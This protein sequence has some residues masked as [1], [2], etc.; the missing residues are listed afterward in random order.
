MSTINDYTAMLSSV[1][2]FCLQEMSSSHIL[3]DLVCSFEILAP[4]PLHRS[5]P[6]DLDKVLKYLS[7]PHFEP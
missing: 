6:W 4:R 2:K 7:G 1:F 3:K 5:P